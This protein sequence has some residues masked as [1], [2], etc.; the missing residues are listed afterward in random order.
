MHA[1][2]DACV[3]VINTGGRAYQ[4]LEAALHEEVTAFVNEHTCSHTTV[5]V[6]ERL[7]RKGLVP[8]RSEL[9]GPQQALQL[10]VTV[11]ATTVP[12]MSIMVPR[13]LLNVRHYWTL[14][15]YKHADARKSSGACLS[16][17]VTVYGPPAVSTV[18]PLLTP[19]SSVTQQH[20]GL[21]H[22]HV[23]A[24]QTDVG[25]TSANVHH[26]A[27]LLRVQQQHGGSTTGGSTAG[28]F[29][30]GC[31]APSPTASSSYHPAGGAASA[32]A[33]A[34]ASAYDIWDE[35]NRQQ[36]LHQQQHQHQQH[37]LA[38]GSSYSSRP[39]TPR[40]PHTPASGTGSAV[41]A[42]LASD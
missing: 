4:C 39:L 16:V 31:A 25:H 6:R 11:P 2:V 15:L 41:L 24:V 8:P 34:S 5:L 42:P 20:A 21:L 10:D 3:Q 30:G 40:T 29:T 14:E 1:C 19:Q 23:P 36:H 22:A 37:H 35:H 32:S 12:D 9:S 13:P 17:D 26:H 28:S 27:G 38:G 33:S 18:P 7:Q